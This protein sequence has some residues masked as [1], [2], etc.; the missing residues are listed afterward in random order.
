MRT[1]SQALP[2]DADRRIRNFR[3]TLRYRYNLDRPKKFFSC[4]GMATS[5]YVSEWC[6]INGLKVTP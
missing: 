5:L 4:Y 2:A 3:R 1:F 6:R